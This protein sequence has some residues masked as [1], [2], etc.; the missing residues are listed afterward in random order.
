MEQKIKDKILICV[1][2]NEEFVFTVGAQ[3]YFTQR[4]FSEAPKRCKSCYMDLKK[5]RRHGEREVPSGE[6]H[7][8]RPE[9]QVFNLLQGNGNQGDAED[10]HNLK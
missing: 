1:D 3:E 6:R 2:C 4:G 10:R 9:D 8:V 7:E 5:V